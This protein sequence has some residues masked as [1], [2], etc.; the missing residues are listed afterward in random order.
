MCQKNKSQII[1]MICD[2]MSTMRALP[3]K[4]VAITGPKLKPIVM[5]AGSIQTEVPHEEADVLIAY[6]AIQEASTGNTSITDISD[7]T[8]VLLILAH[9]RYHKTNRIPEDT[10]IVMDTCSRSNTVSSVVQA[11]INIMP[12]IVSA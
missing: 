9:H 4:Q 10:V 12:N 3:E 7:D 2:R 6:H 1:Q 11:N 8:D 5:G